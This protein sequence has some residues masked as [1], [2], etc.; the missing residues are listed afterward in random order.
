MAIE[1]IY[2]LDAESVLKALDQVIGKAGD[3]EQAMAKLNK[4]D[5]FKDA[6]KSAPDLN[7]ELSDGAKNYAQITATA[8]TYK[9]EIKKV[10]VEHEKLIAKKKEFDAAGKYSEYSKELET[11]QGKLGKLSQ[12][13]ENS[14]K[15]A[16]GLRG[17]VGNVTGKLKDMVTG[18][19]AAES[20]LG[21]FL[22]AAITLFGA[23]GVAIA[24]S[25]AFVYKARQGYLEM[26]DALLSTSGSQ[27]TVSN[28]MEVL[29][30]V[31]D[32][33]G[34]T[35]REVTSAYG[36]FNSNGLKPTSSQ[37][38]NLGILSQELKT[39]FGTLSKAITDADSGQTTSLKNLGIQSVTNGNKIKLSFRGITTE[40]KKGSG[41]SIKALDSISRQIEKT[42]NS[43]AGVG[44]TDF[45]DKFA[46][47]MVDAEQSV[48][49]AAESVNGKAYPAFDRFISLM[50]RGKTVALDLA[51]S[52]GIWL[53]MGWEKIKNEAAF[54]VA[55]L[56]YIPDALKNGLTVANKNFS[57]ASAA[58][59]RNKKIIAEQEAKLQP[60]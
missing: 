7:K 1:S 45:M 30:T 54:L 47:G 51:E 52:F 28:N 19:S 35:L 16:G 40:F 3:A 48:S 41:D 44:R 12:G 38:K 13:L 57:D 58:F 56:A 33:L 24:A 50:E 20:T 11:V 32:Q 8:E 39:D 43:A 37:M 36:N 59:L 53:G 10:T 49:A 26:N 34:I 9:E 46:K 15:S 29:D 27:K 23:L 17:M 14:T 60:V 2:T 21:R 22:P 5:P 55:T 31:A 4:V 6:A 42:E 25:V 18:S